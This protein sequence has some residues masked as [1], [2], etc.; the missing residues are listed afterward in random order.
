MLSTPLSSPPASVIDINSE[1]PIAAVAA[2]VRQSGSKRK[3][4]SPVTEQLDDSHLPE[5]DGSVEI[6]NDDDSEYE[7]ESI[8]E[9]AIIDVSIIWILQLDHYYFL[10]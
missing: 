7:I 4:L 6:E 9:V 1:E 3:A 2:N 10:L 5:A 8:Q